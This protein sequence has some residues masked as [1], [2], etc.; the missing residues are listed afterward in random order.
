MISR[1]PSSINLYTNDANL[2]AALTKSFHECSIVEVNGANFFCV[3]CRGGGDTFEL[4]EIF[5]VKPEK[6]VEWPNG[7]PPVGATCERR[8]PNVESSSWQ[9]GIVLAHGSRKI[10][11]RDNCGDEWAHSIDDVEFRSFR[12]PEQIAAEDRDAG[13]QALKQIFDSCS[14][15]LMPTS[16]KYLDTLFGAIYDAGYRKF[17]IVDN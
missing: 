15:E 4:R 17:E 5:C 8:F 13:I 3:M 7:I 10:F 16:N 9:G 1:T 11:F 14:D 12:T 6:V 2:K